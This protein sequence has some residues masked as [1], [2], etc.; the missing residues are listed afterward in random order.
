M[1]LRFGE[2]FL[3]DL[4]CYGLFQGWFPSYFN[5][6]GLDVVLIAKRLYGT[7]PCLRA[8]GRFGWWEIIVFSAVEVG[9]WLKWQ[10]YFFLDS[11]QMGYMRQ[12]VYQ[13]IFAWSIFAMGGLLLNCPMCLVFFFFFFSDVVILVWVL[14][15]FRWL[16][17]YFGWS[18][19]P[20]FF[21]NK[22]F[23][24]IKKKKKKM[25]S[26]IGCWEKRQT[27]FFHM[28]LSVVHWFYLLVVWLV[29]M[30]IRGLSE[31][32]PRKTTPYLFLR[33]SHD[34]IGFFPICYLTRLF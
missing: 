6:G 12:G 33:F 11:F 30:H 21:R 23:V 20:F 28:Y 8:Y 4:V 13:C 7:F 22:I 17:L 3:K 10:F 9:R 5:S 25:N 27:Q 34:V 16:L 26:R 32:Q 31:I 24:V 19:V 14:V 29:N 18:F 15:L 2:L 1:L